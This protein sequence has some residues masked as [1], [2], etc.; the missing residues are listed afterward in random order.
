M[1]L[2]A[3][4]PPLEKLSWKQKVKKSLHRHDA[5]IPLE[6]VSV[7]RQKVLE[8]TAA[9]PAAPLTRRCWW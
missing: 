5:K 7:R 8:R 9:E 4:N 3:N 6:K 1:W 2:N